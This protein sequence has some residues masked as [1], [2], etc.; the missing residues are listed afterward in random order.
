MDALLAAV[1]VVARAEA[2]ARARNP[3][4]HLSGPHLLAVT[5]WLLAIGYGL[6]I[7]DWRLA[8]DDWQLESANG[9]H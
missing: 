5:Y 2:V 6:A 8:N 1:E 3:R 7:G 9:G 4:W